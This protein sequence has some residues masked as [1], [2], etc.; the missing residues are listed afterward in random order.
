MTPRWSWA[1]GPARVALGAALCWSAISAASLSRPAMAPEQAQALW[2]SAQAQHS[3]GRFAEALSSVDR[4]LAT[5]PDSP[6]YLSFAA[7]L[8]QD[9]KDPA[10]EAAAWQ[11]FM[12]VAP[13][14]TEAC[15]RIG[16]AYHSLGQYDKSLAAYRR[17]LDLDPKKTDLLFFLGQ[18]LASQDRP[19]EAAKAYA[20]ALERSPDSSDTLLGLARLR[21]QQNDIPGAKALVDRVLANSPK[22]TDAL[23]DAAMIAEKLGDYKQAQVYL[24]TAIAESPS[25]ADLY[26]MLG[27]ISLEAEDRPA[28]LKAFAALHDLVP[29]DADAARRLSELQAASTP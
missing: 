9:L 19:Q 17:C 1:E 15:P 16:Q 26:R 27:R 14:P 8:F 4:L 10:R 7:Q 5:F 29:D 21:L 18:E 20:Q 2:D 6:I 11:I 12:A 25:Y 24:T 3:A 13:F 23:A 28:A 22:N